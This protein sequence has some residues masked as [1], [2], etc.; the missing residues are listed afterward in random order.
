LLVLLGLFACVTP[1]QA[2]V[3][4]APPVVAESAPPAPPPPPPAPPP[5]VPVPF[6]DAVA[7]AADTLFSGAKVPPDER[8][9][10]LIDPLIDG[11]TGEQTQATRTM[12]SHI[13]Q[14]VRE[15]YPRFDVQP[16]SVEN[17]KKSP[18]ILVGTFTG[19]NKDGKTEGTREAF[20]IC[21]ALADLDNRVL[22][23][24]GTARAK[25]ENVDLTPLPYFRDS[26]AWGLD[27]VT[28]GYIKTCQ[29]SK[30]GDPMDPLYVARVVSAASVQQAISA[31]NAGHYRES[32]NFYA[33]AMRAAA[34]DELRILNGVYLANIKLGQKHAAQ[35]VFGRI[36]DFGLD[37]KR[38][39][40]KFLFKPGS[41]AFWPDPKVSGIYPVWLKE[42]ATRSDKQQACLEIVG[43]TS[44]SGPEPVNERISLLRA[45]LIKG[46]LDTDAPSLR[47][48]TIANGVGSR[49]NLIG[50]G[51]DNITDML[52]RR[53]SFRVIDCGAKAG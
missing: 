9:I 51:Q 24:K 48:R 32:L 53:V 52:D 14:I 13:T 15:R 43:H 41:T 49:E 34:G 27:P 10:V 39:A 19:V 40:V 3:A 46:K 29:A 44:R 25:P 1:P 12:E 21:L 4:P 22:V 45:E 26:P 23:G 7:K 2:P 16:F 28:E 17:L 5:V 33:V 20:R 35:L 37:R 8:R 42:I 38:L 6:D 31:Y 30:P 47:A 36:V 50:N 18:L 11:M